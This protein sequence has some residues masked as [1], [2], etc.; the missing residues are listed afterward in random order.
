[1]G[2]DGMVSDGIHG[3]GTG[4]TA[5]WGK[6]V[7]GACACLPACLLDRRSNCLMNRAVVAHAESIRILADFYLRNG[8]RTALPRATVD[9][10]RGH[11]M[12]AKEALPE[13]EKKN[14]LGF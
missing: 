5:G 9:S 3:T 13:P 10:V 14:F 2:W 8:Q 7:L 6:V 1:M 12:T 4:T 11:L